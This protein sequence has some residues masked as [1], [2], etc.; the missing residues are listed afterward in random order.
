MQVYW[1]RNQNRPGDLQEKILKYEGALIKL[2]VAEVN[3][4]VTH[5]ASILGMSYQSLSYIIESR[6]TEL[7]K[8]RTPIRRRPQKIK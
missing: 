8:D 2:A 6:H 3:G 5:A 1:H 7:L 4:S